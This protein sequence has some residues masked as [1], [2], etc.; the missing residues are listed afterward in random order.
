MNYFSIRTEDY[1]VLLDA[2]TIIL[3]NGT[4]SPKGQPKALLR[5]SARG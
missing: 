2:I 4:V 5:F 3:A 1:R